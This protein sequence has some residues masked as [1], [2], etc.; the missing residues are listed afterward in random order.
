LPQ[1]SVS[2]NDEAAGLPRAFG[3]GGASP[4]LRSLS[5]VLRLLSSVSQ[6]LAPALLLLIQDVGALTGVVARKQGAAWHFSAPARSG[7]A[8]FGH[9]LDAVLARLRQQGERVPRRSFLAARAIVPARVDLPV[10]PEK[11]RPLL[12]MREMAR[13]EMEPAVAEFGALWNLGG[14]LAAQGLITPETRERITLELAVRREGANNKPTYYGQVACELGF[15]TPEDLEN[16]LRAQE[17]LQML[18][19]WL[20]CG[21]NGYAEESG[22]PPVWLAS[23]TGLSLW[24]QFERA[25]KE[26][27]LKLL[28][29][30]PLAW[31][32]SETP[33]ETEGGES[34]VALEIHAEEIVAVL[35]HRGRV[36]A[37][38][39]EG[40]ME[41][42]LAVERL[43]HLVSD[44][45]AAGARDLEIVCVDPADEAALA[46]LREE[47]G[48]H[49]G[50]APRFRDAAATQQAVLAALA[51]QYR[52]MRGTLP[53]IRFGELP[54]PPWKK[55]GFW[56]VAAPLLTLAAVGA[57]AFQQHMQIRAIQ[58]RFAQKAAES[59]KSA[60]T[61]QQETRIFQELQQSQHALAEARKKLLQ[62]A[63]EVERL[64]NI[65]RMTLLLPQLLR[66]LAANI[67][68]N[69]VLE[70]VESSGGVSDIG[71]VRV[72]AW[73]NDY[74]SAQ[75]FA[76]R[77]Q[78]TLGGMGYAVAQ[79]DVRGA[80]G[81]DKQ[82]GYLVSF[83]LIP[84]AGPDELGAAEAPEQAAPES[85]GPRP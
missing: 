51:S 7:V 70:S 33:G 67:G 48:E 78:G 81:R 32:A 52:N 28:G 39:G 40:R 71:N 44:W 82:H 43:L 69:V 9:A 58:Q 57:V 68:E 41:R 42:P 85:G 61:R 27:G 74:T 19:T 1:A 10:S 35:R 62:T 4:A 30:L 83:W 49:W 14:V 23:A 65:E 17:K 13:A 59:Q 77:M 3:Q 54:R 47:I 34:R 53:L 79:T 11:P 5:S 80:P 8:D 50:H 45:R 26:H 60:E 16:A 20:A 36:A 56:H 46:A 2:R 21:W 63:P 64:E 12:Q 75:D 25:L 73:S 76:Q 18:E 31:S 15:I 72:T 55:T 6:R 29:A 37:A 38:R 66:A 84:T 22:E 24:S